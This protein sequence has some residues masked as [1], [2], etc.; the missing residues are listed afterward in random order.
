MPARRMRPNAPITIPIIAGVLSVDFLVVELLRVPVPEAPE[1]AVG[2]VLP[3][4]GEGLDTLPLDFTVR[5]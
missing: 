4:V 1:G 3:L 2:V 5:L